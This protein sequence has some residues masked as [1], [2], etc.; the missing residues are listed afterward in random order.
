MDDFAI[1]GIPTP[2]PRQSLQDVGVLQTPP[3]LGRQCLA[4]VLRSE[5]SEF[6]LDVP[7]G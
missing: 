5:P 2:A 7:S 3:A 4:Q 1:S 6:K